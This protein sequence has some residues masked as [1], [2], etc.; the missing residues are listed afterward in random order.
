[1]TDRQTSDGQQICVGNSDTMYRGRHTLLPLMT[2]SR[3]VLTATVNVRLTTTLCKAH[4]NVVTAHWLQRTFT[5][6]CYQTTTPHSRQTTTPQNTL[7]NG[8][9]AEEYGCHGSDY[10]SRT[11]SFFPS[12]RPV[13]EST[14]RT[15]CRFCVASNLDALDAIISIKYRRPLGRPS[16]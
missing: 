2:T 3:L 4:K 5:L 11:P 15:S 1:M 10:E 7:N 13:T 9:P 12:C 16:V 6:K 14:D 8:P